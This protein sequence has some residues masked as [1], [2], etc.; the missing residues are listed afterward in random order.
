[1]R[2]AFREKLDENPL[3]DEED[4]TK[5]KPVVYDWQIQQDGAIW[6]DGKKLFQRGKDFVLKIYIMETD[7]LETEEE[8]KK[9]K[10]INADIVVQVNQ[11]YLGKFVS[12]RPI[13]TL[14][15]IEVPF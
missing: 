6:K 11:E 3:L 2:N 10:K 13:W 5:P 7:E 14:E 4:P 8:K 9:G 15:W 12:D 1:M